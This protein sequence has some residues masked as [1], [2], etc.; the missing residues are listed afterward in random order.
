M[1]KGEAFRPPAHVRMGTSLF[2]RISNVTTKLTLD[3]PLGD[4]DEDLEE[5]EKD[6]GDIELQG[7][8]SDDG[9]TAKLN[10]KQGS[11][12]GGSNRGSPKKKGLKRTS[13]K[14]LNPGVG[15]NDVGAEHKIL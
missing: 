5:K 4:D 14:M 12:S 13:S 1:T 10:L 2:L 9:Q 15:L 6:T 8:A 3:G 7:K 11:S